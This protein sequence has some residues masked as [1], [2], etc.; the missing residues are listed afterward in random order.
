MSIDITIG[1]KMQSLPNPP[2]TNKCSL[3]NSECCLRPVREEYTRAAPLI[4]TFNPQSKA[5]SLQGKNTDF[6]SAGYW[7]R[8]LEETGLDK[9]FNE[10]FPYEAATSLAPLAHVRARL[11][12]V[13]DGLANGTL[14]TRYSQD[15]RKTL[16]WLI[17]WWDYA[18]EKYGANA[19]LWYH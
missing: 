12:E 16:D 17:W 8:V 14:T 6:F 18:L 19:V 15:D 9:L 4:R 5:W 13:S 10:T 1:E 3:A 2:C 11:G 7:F